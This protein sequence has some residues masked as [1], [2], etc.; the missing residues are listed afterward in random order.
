MAIAGQ[1]QRIVA[2]ERTDNKQ[3][4]RRIASATSSIV[5]CGGGYRSLGSSI[6]GRR[7]DLT[8]GHGVVPFRGRRRPGFAGEIDLVAAQRGDAADRSG[9]GVLGA[10]SPVM[11]M[12]CCQAMTSGASASVR[13]SWGLR[14]VCAPVPVGV[15][16]PASG[17]GGKRVRVVRCRACARPVRI[18]QS[19]GSVRE[20]KSVCDM[21]PLLRLE[22][23]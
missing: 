20:R 19:A 9:V 3:T 22:C 14:A 4:R 6:R 12:G 15:A 10:V 13:I 7:A 23:C 21:P 11:G 18:S 8:S 2:A 17:L 5:W 1:V 16:R